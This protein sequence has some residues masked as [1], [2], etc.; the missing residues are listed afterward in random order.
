M[1][2]R[3]TTSRSRKMRNGHYVNVMSYYIIVNADVCISVY[4]LLL[5]NN[6]YKT[7][8]HIFSQN[9]LAHMFTKHP[10]T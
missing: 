4:P 9:T 10:R 8:S 7:P 3:L 2:P 1:T 6:Y 5:F